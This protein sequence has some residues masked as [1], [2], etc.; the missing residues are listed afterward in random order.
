MWVWLTTTASA[1]PPVT[2][3]V[4]PPPLPIKTRPAPN[5]THV[6]KPNNVFGLVEIDDV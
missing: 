3:A 5:A 2:P 1:L 4:N 6:P